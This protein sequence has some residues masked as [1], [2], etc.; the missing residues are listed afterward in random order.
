MSTYYYI[1]A[2]AQVDGKWM[3]LNPILYAHN[4]EYKSSE[5]TYFTHSSYAEVYYALSDDRIACG[6]PED[7]NPITAGHFHN[8]DEMS[9]GWP[10]NETWREYYRHEVFVV[11][12]AQAIKSRT[13]KDRPH[14][15]MYYVTRE[16]MAAF[17]CGELDS[18]EHWITDEEYRSLSEEEKKDYVYYEWD[19]WYDEYR[20]YREIED[21]VDAQ[22]AFFNNTYGLLEGKYRSANITPGQVR[23]IIERC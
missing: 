4:G 16:S 11:N 20:V 17:E 21:R 6:L 10:K 15:Y 14:K 13:R 1:F 18:I 8:L 9:D 7:C 12:Y 5:I 19:N 3:N 22:I 23:L 2:E